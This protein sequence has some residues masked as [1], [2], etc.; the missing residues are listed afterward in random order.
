[1]TTQNHYKTLLA[2]GGALGA[3]IASPVFAEG[4]DA[5]TLIENTATATYDDGGGPISISSNTVSVL[6]DELLDVA[7]T[8]LDPGTIATQPG[9]EVLTFELTN[10][11]NG[12]EAFVLE[13]LGSVAGN[14]FDATITDIA[15][16]TNGNGT[17]DPGVDEI[18]AAPRTTAL[19]DA[20]ASLTIFVL[21]D[22]PASAADGNRSDIDLAARAVTGTGAPGTVFTGEGVSGGDAIA[23]A[24]GAIDN[25]IGTLLVGTAAV[26]L[27]KAVSIADQFGGTG[28]VPG[29]TASFT[30]IASVSGTGSIDD[31][32]ISDPIPEG[33]TYAPGTLAL[34]GAALTDASGDDAGQASDA[35]GIRVDLGT[36]AGGASHTITFDVVID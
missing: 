15:V 34:G 3:G 1:M 5:G 18:L 25:E 13:A 17:Y 20:D 27:T 31:L 23:G 9:A 22:V 26:A 11:G 16:D 35:D 2:I 36:M 32:V 14:D 10:T 28:A 19:L 12:P 33:T 30:I 4:V 29:A 21:A 24:S 8:S 6:V 7:V